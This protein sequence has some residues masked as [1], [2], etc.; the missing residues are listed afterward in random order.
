MDIRKP[1]RVFLFVFD[2]LRFI[3]LAVSFMLMSRIRTEGS[4]EVFPYMAYLSANALFP[5]ITMFLLFKAQEYSNYL[6]LYIA[7]KTISVVLFY[8]WVVVILP[9]EAGMVRRENYSEAMLLLGSVFLVS[10]EDALSIIGSLVLVK[11]T[12]NVRAESQ[13]GL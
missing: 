1:I 4:S 6:P 7:G 5:L 10:L 2:L 12:R 13:G 11:K 9:F 3:L 8:I